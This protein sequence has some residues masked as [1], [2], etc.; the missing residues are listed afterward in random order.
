MPDMGNDIRGVIELLWSRKWQ[1]LAAALIGG[2]VATLIAWRQTPIYASE[3]KV[4][5]KSVV[6]SPTDSAQT[7]DVNMDTE[8]ELAISAPVAELVRKDLDLP[9]AANGLAADLNVEVA[10]STEILSFT[11]EAADPEVAQQRAQA[12]A[13]AY[14]AYRLQQVTDETH[15]RRRSLQAQGRALTAKLQKVT[16][17]IAATHAAEVLQPLRLQADSLANL[18]VANQLSIL[19][20]PLHPAVGA[21]VQPATPPGDPSGPSDAL[22]IILGV[23]IG[24]AAGTVVVLLRERLSDRPRSAQ[25]VE[26]KLAAPVLALVPAK[27]RFRDRKRSAFDLW[28]DPNSALAES[29]RILRTNLLA[30]PTVQPPFTILVTSSQSGE[31]K[32]TVAAH[33]GIA[34]ALAGHDVVVVDAALR[35]PTLHRLFR[36]PASP[37]LT[38]VLT[39]GE[40]LPTTVRVSDLENFRLLT[41]GGSVERPVELLG[42]DQMRALLRTLA[43]SVEVVVIDGG[44]VLGSADGLT[45]APLADEILVVVDGNISDGRTIQQA[46]RLLDLLHVPIVGGVL[47]RYSPS[48]ARRTSA[49]SGYGRSSDGDVPRASVLQAAPDP[50]VEAQRDR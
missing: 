6:L 45:L 38:E 42:S 27:R 41:S 14:L 49:E 5:V 12:F 15:Q 35:R 3:A 25:A 16:T 4:L 33:L 19:S 36:C 44:S 46:R 29:F 26:K 48:E 2:L 50:R 37:G 30:S 28:D 21:V 40:D 18:I 17:D 24:A 7:I 20:F 47:N 8:A 10:P 1:V 23:L 31:G 43:N 32:T 34:L 9:D 22:I 13:D 11:Y 39:K